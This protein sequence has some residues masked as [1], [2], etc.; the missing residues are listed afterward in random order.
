M[1]THQSQ[2]LRIQAQANSPADAIRSATRTCASLFQMDGLIGEVA[3]GCFAG[4]PVQLDHVCASCTHLAKSGWIPHGLAGCLLH[5]LQASACE[6]FAFCLSSTSTG[7]MK[8]AWH[9]ATADGM[10]LNHYVGADLIVLDT[11]P[12]EDITAFERP[13]EFVAVMHNG[14]FVRRQAGL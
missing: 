14:I 11:D 10:T 7:S 3:A 6:A 4:A 1:R 5:A 12:L 13:E 9:F 8:D 2:G